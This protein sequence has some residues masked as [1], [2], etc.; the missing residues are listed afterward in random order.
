[1][2]ETGGTLTF[3]LARNETSCIFTRTF[4]QDWSLLLYHLH[5]LVFHMVEWLLMFSD[6]GFYFIA[7]I[8]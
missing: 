4:L 2:S 7:H 3:S 5:Q 1:M 6:S 8:L